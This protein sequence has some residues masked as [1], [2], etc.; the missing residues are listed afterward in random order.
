V[1]DLLPLGGFPSGHRHNFL[2]LSESS[3]FTRLFLRSTIWAPNTFDYTRLDSWRPGIH[4]FVLSLSKDERAR[5]ETSTQSPRIIASFFLR[6]QP[7]ICCSE[8][9]ASSRCGEF[10]RED[11]LERLPFEGKASRYFAF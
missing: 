3:R 5:C 8:A 11:Q 4:P 1:H 6:L 7:L 2:Y 9:R 10:L